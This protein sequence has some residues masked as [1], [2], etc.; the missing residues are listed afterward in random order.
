MATMG[1]DYGTRRVGIAFSYSDEIATPHSV[2]RNE[3]DLEILAGRIAEL[4]EELE[5]ERLVLGLPRQRFHSR[6]VDRIEQ[7]AALLRQKTCKE[8]LLWNESYSTTEAD[9]KRRERGAKTR[10][11]KEQIDM[12][13]AAVILQ[14]WLDGRE[15]LS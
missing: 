13:A 11:R 9:S 6:S 12:E 4:A 1:I 7:F 3:G 2:I 5:A 8:V 15:K 10:T 14:S